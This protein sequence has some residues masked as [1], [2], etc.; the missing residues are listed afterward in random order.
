MSARV[1][2]LLAR[3]EIRDA[4]RN[5]W[6]LLYGGAFAVLALSLSRLALGEPGTAG[7]AG[8]GRT[9][10]SLVNL[11][12]LI[13]P[14]MG[15]TLGAG[16][17]AGEAERGTLAGLLAQP[18]SRV[19]V[20]IGKFAGLSLALNAALSLGFGLAA[21]AVGRAGADVDAGA[22]ALLVA[23]TILLSLVAIALGML[24]S[25]LSRQLGAALGTALFAW[26]TLVFLG[27]LGLLGMAM[28]MRMDT[29]S[30]LAISLA[31]PL[32]AFKIA[33]VSSMTGSLDVLGPAG[34]LAT[35][36]YGA[37]LLPLLAGLLLSWTVLTLL[38]AGLS[39]RRRP[40]F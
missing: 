11:V 31:N 8:F 6:F 27:D 28:T 37:G 35:R 33:A 17:I 24:I 4:L 18:I 14:L 13:V 7:F 26:L 25:V 10:A 32:M 2:L 34:L 40:V 39:F 21:L 16:S 9:A 3:K 19:E 15:L 20:L 22:Y 38:L 23:F 29:S 5:R 30:L 12:L 36:T 1:I